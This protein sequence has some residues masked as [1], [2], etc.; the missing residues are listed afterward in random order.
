MPADPAVDTRTKIGLAGLVI[1]LIG[2]PAW[3]WP[4][5]TTEPTDDRREA[6]R[7][8]PKRRTTRLGPDRRQRLG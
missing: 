1:A 6:G 7:L 5:A 2:V 8:S 4:C 3:R